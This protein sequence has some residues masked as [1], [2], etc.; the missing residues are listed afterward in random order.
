V[1]HR[2]WPRPAVA[3]LTAAALCVG[4]PLDPSAQPTR[5]KPTTLAAL[6]AYT[7]FFHRQPV[8][9][10]AKAEG[11]LRNMFVT[12]GQ[13]RIRALNLLP[14]LGSR[15]E[16]L[17]ISGTFWDV[18]RLQPNDPRLVNHG[19]QGLSERLF[20]KPWPSSGE[21][22]LLVATETRAVHEPDDTTIRS[23]TLEPTRYRDRAV[24]LTGRFRGRN[25]YGDL[26]EA[27][28]TSPTD[29]VLQSAE[30]AVW[31]VGK[32]PRGD[33]FNLDVMARVDTGRWL[34]VSGTVRG[35]ERLVEIEAVEIDQIDRPV[36]ADPPPTFIED[37]TKAAP[38][39]EVIF[40][41]PTPN[42]TNVALDTALRFQFSRD[43]DAGSLPGS[44]A[45]RYFGSTDTEFEFNVDYRPRNRVVTVTFTEPL[46]P[47]RTIE[48]NLGNSILATDGTALVPHTLRFST[49][50]S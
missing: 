38:A 37:L 14:P 28:G 39:P 2:R 27:P 7:T 42:D 20:D 10:L 25:L 8:V 30:A 45:V 3:V 31:I 26:P 32:E 1:S 12:D 36:Q 40:S 9:V 16:L 13:R 50:G 23:V 19:I 29:F 47:Y 15:S 41:T 33:G 6:D 48:A 44:V 11:D 46:L 4:R 18:G 43:I 24:T 21:L 35:S 5:Y 34:R 22:Q 17:E 49:G